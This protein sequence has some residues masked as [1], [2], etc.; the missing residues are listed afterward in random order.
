LLPFGIA[1]GVVI[2]A[3]RMAD[4]VG[5]IGAPVLYGGSA[6]LDGDDDVQ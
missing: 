5:V 2:A 4:V 3:T 6:Q 1:L